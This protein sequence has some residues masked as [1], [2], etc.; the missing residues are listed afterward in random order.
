M[1]LDLQEP[2]KSLWS[3]GYLVNDGKG[4][5]LA[6]CSRSCAAS[7]HSIKGIDD[8]VKQQIKELKLSGLSS[9]KISELVGISR[10]TVMKYW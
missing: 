3:K 6:F 10:T 2:F 4:Q 5:E 7:Y 1:I 8:S 9:Y